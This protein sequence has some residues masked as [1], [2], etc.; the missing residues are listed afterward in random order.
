MSREEVIVVGAGLTG[1]SAAWYL[2]QRGIPAL[3]LEAEGEVGGNVRSRAEGG[4]LRDLGPNSLMVKGELLP[5][6][7]RR[8][9]LEDRVVEANPLARRR[10]VLNRKRRPVALGPGVLLSSSLLSLSARLRLLSE[11]WRAARPASHDDESIADF[12]RRRLGPEALAWLVDPFVSGVFAGDPEKLSVSAA[13][14]RLAS[15]E[16]ESGSLLRA[17]L[18][19]RRTG[20]KGTGSRLVSFRSGLQELPMALAGALPPDRLQRSRAVIGIQHSEEGW[21]LQTTGGELECRHLVLALPASEI[22]RLLRPLAAELADE[23]DAIFYPAVATIALGFPRE[24]VAHPLDGFGLLIPRRLGI[25][26]LGVLFSSTLFPERAPEGMV[27]L[28]AFLGGAQQDISQRSPAELE[29][30]ALRDLRP[31]LGI[32]GDPSY[33]RCALW[34]RAIPQYALGH[35]ERIARIHELCRRLPNLDLLGN[36]QGGVA[37]GD[38]VAQAN[39]FQKAFM[40]ARTATGQN[41]AP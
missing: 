35:G 11:P 33:H 24:A 7:I 26:T 12:V 36:W 21:R 29:A 40:E 18:R 5:D 22:A 20:K 15:M 3:L 41:E 6:M 38:C 16:A 19:N 17:A 34:P 2:H 13:L 37:L 31:I 4:F 1:L 25:E 27:L 9:G 8:L 14:P 39:A 32:R 28:T 30:Q 10:F 23:L